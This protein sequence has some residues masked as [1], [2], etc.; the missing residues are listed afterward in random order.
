MSLKRATSPGTS[1]ELV[2]GNKN[3]HESNKALTG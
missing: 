2:N 1:Q 3:N